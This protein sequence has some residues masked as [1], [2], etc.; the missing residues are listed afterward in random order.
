MNEIPTFYEFVDVL[1]A[2]LFAADALKRAELHDFADL[3]RRED[4]ADLIPD[5]WYDDAFDELKT[6]GHLHPAS[7]KAMGPTM[8]GYRL[9]AAHT[10]AGSRSRRT[11]CPRKRTTDR[12]PSRPRERPLGRSPRR[13]I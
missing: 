5:N 13:A 11:T 7:G 3:M 1:R 4:Y 2:R 6:Q 10:S 9:T 8:H 12:T